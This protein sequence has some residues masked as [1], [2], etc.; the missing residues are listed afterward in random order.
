MVLPLPSS[1]RGQH[2]TDAMRAELV[3]ALT[4]R[5]NQALDARLRLDPHSPVVVLDELLG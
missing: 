4:E 1:P 5:W 3:D 2:V